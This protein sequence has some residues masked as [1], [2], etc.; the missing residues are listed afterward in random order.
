MQRGRSR[1][2][3]RACSAIQRGER[4]QDITSP[5]VP[6][7]DPT[8]DP[9]R[10]LAR[11]ARRAAHRRR[12]GYR[13]RHEQ[14]DD[15]PP[16]DSRR[17]AWRRRHRCRRRGPPVRRRAERRRG[18][19]DADRRRLPGDPLPDAGAGRARL[20]PRRDDA[21]LGLAV[22]S[23]PGAALAGRPG[24]AGRAGLAGRLH[25]T[26]R[27]LRAVVQRPA[28]PRRRRPA[29]GAGHHPARPH[30]QPPGRGCPSRPQRRVGDLHRVG[31]RGGAVR[32][33]SG[34]S[35]GDHAAPGRTAHHRGHRSQ[36][37]RPA[38]G[39]AAAVSH[40]HRPTAVG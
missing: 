21:G 2:T 11:D 18:H 25:R 1:R 3:G 34:A 19:R 10:A 14:A 31:P 35:H 17:H 22:G 13:H 8:R 23:G 40:Q 20:Q 12:A 6:T 5:S 30:R 29:A 26:G 38:A 15:R 28:R 27:A 39:D 24:V 33:R 32:R 36:H 4:P 7:R 16:N 37:R 9:I